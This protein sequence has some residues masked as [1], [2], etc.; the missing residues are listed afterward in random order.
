[1]LIDCEKVKHL[2]EMTQV[3]RSWNSA[4]NALNNDLHNSYTSKHQQNDYTDKEQEQCGT[5]RECAKEK[6]KKDII[7][8]QVK[9]RLMVK[10]G[11]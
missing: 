2:A 11:T 7:A 5:E 3:E 9:K 8:N 6:K 10:K 4:I 1:L